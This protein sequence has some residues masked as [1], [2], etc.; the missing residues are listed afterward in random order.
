MFRKHGSFNISRV[1]SHRLDALLYSRRQPFGI[2]VFSPRA[3]RF[4]PSSLGLFAALGKG[5]DCFHRPC[6]SA[7]CPLF[8]AHFACRSESGNIKDRFY[9]GGVS[10]PASCD[11]LLVCSR[12]VR[13]QRCWLPMPRAPPS[14]LCSRIVS[15]FTW[16]LWAYSQA[17]RSSL[18]SLWLQGGSLCRLCLYLGAGSLRRTHAW[19]W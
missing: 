1:H 14:P 15:A 5:T 16:V 10:F 12:G 6:V 19:G 13:L 3:W 2:Q 8:Q 9:L 11:S 4:H 18:S 7:C 17:R